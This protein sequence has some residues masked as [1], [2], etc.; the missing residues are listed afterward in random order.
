MKQLVI[1]ID[2]D[3]VLAE[4]AVG[5]VAFSNERWGTRLTTDDYDEHWAKMRNI[6]NQE[7]ER[8][9]REFHGSSMMLEY[10]HIGGA[11]ESLSRLAEHHHLVI[12]TSRRLRIRDVARCGERD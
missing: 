7:V 5:F 11:F 3:D 9:A 10:G 12:A 1:A 4:N 2:C 6:D 8:R